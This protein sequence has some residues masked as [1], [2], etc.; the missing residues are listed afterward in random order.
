MPGL[1]GSSTAVGDL[2]VILKYAPWR[3]RE[4]GS[5]VSVGLAV[6]APTGPNSFAGS[7]EAAPL[8]ST[9]LQPYVGYLG[10]FSDFYLHGFSSIDVPTDLRDVTILYNDVGIGYHLY[11]ARD[12]GRWITAVTPTFEVHVNTPLDHRGSR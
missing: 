7:P 4:S 6:T 10:N 3:D 2:S 9:T 12:E 11:R 8:L 5:L 1:G